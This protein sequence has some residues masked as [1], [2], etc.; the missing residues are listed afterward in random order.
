MF[1]SQL[2]QLCFTILVFVVGLNEFKST[3]N[4]HT[5]ADPVQNVTIGP[6]GYTDGDSCIMFEILN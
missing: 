6:T 5:F 2:L 4:I 3:E 1:L